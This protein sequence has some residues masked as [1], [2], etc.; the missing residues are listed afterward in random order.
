M[1]QGLPD[2][3]ILTVEEVAAYLRVSERTVYE[4]AHKGEMPCGKLGTTWRF[5]RSE[6]QDWVNERLAR[7]RPA[8]VRVAV[9]LADVLT[10]ERVLVLDVATKREAL[11]ALIDCLARAP[12]V[13]DRRELAA[14][15]F[16]RED[17]MSTGIGL[18]VG[19][20]HVRLASVREVVVAVGLSRRDIADYASLDGRPVRVV[21]MVAAG[22]DQHA[23][24]L[25]V[26]AAVTARLRDERCREA[27][28]AAPDPAAAWT[29]LTRDAEP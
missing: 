24:Y 18:G 26:L 3:E 28:R 9:R 12:G 4:W 5:M 1:S 15:V 13:A 7:S 29:I 16:R 8:A 14:E 6:V 11:E 2:H 23:E 19:V 20:P 27:L 17:L 25:R 21:C 10:P 22:K